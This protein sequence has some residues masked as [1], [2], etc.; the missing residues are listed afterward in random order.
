MARGALIAAI[1]RKSMKLS[2]KARTV[3]T[4]GKLINH[5]STDV[6]RIDFCAG[7]F[8]MSWTAFVQIFIII[9]LLLANLGPSSLAGVAFLFI[10]T[11]VP[12]TLHFWTDVL[13]GLVRRWR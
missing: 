1:Y 2:G 11:Y 5:I 3:I 12:L 13:A 9:A 10:T 4:N 8:H 6:S 7:F